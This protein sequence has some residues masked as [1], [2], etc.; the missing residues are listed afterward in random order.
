MKSLRESTIERYLVAQV[1]KRGG[2][3]YKFVSPGNRGV[4]DRI[5]IFPDEVPVFIELK[6]PGGKLSA[7][8]KAQIKT[9]Q[10]LGCDVCVVRSK[11]EVD[12]WI[13]ETSRRP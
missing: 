8:Q 1:K 7:N 5:V 4:P 6:A 3:A 9:L 13:Y 11:Q 2:R 12:E 10:D